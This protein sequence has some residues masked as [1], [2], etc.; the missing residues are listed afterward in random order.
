[1]PLVK[2]PTKEE[3]NELHRKFMDSITELFNTE[4][5]KYIRNPDAKLEII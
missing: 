4:K 1:M 3:I 2:N 5:H